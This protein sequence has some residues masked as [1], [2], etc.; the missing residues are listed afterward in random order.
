VLH[1]F[2]YIRYT[3]FLTKTNTALTTPN[4]NPLNLSGEPCLVVQLDNPTDKFSAIDALPFSAS[5]SDLQVVNITVKFTQG[6]KTSGEVIIP[7]MFS[8]AE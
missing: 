4:P 5:G 6:G 3:F 8:I 7:V 1:F 2:I